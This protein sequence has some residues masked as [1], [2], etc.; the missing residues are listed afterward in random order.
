MQ[1]G[2]EEGTY[3]Y[4]GRPWTSFVLLEAKE[5]ADAIVTKGYELCERETISKEGSQQGE[6]LN[7]KTSLIC[8]GGLLAFG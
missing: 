3:P 1:Q 6:G 4:Q 8:F 7:F 5:S 2:L